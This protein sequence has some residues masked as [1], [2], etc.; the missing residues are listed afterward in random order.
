VLLPL[1]IFTTWYLASSQFRGYILSLSPRLLTLLHSWRVVGFV[2][3]VLASY[4]I[5]PRLFALPAGWGDIA[6]GLTAPF[7]AYRLAV[8]AHRRIFIF[9]QLL[10]VADLVTAISLGALA[11]LLNPQQLASNAATS[12]PMAAL[13]LS[14]IPTFFV[15]LL[16]I[17]HS[18]SIAQ[19]RRWAA[20][21]D[22]RLRENL[23]TLSA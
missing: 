10:G 5:L 7:V 15:P 9:W 16:L 2:F 23:G 14:L 18:I 13:P 17:L 20:E 21:P 19:A 12:A 22:T 4:N 8:P 11:P 1:A 6:I 3:L